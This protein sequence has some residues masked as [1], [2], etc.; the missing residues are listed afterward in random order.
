MPMYTLH[1]KIQYRVILNADYLKVI[2]TKVQMNIYFP[3]GAAF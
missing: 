1:F 2:E 3:T